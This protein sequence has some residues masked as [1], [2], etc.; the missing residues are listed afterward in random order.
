MVTREISSYFKHGE[1]EVDVYSPSHM[2]LDLEKALDQY[3]SDDE[4]SF[5]A[6]PPG[7]AMASPSLP[8]GQPRAG[9]RVRKNPR[10]SVSQGL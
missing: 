3:E 10:R 1:S 8:P 4:P 2:V 9:S 5:D 6:V 7:C